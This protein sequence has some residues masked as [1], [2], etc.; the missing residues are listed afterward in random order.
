MNQRIKL[1]SKTKSGDLSF[2]E[3]YKQ[4]HL[5]FNNT[6]FCL[7]KR[8][9]ERLKRYI[10]QIEVMYW[11]HKYCSPKIRRK[12]PLPTKQHNLY[13]MFN[14]QEIEELRVLLDIKKDVSSTKLLRLDDIDYTLIIN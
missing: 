6:L 3:E 13:L 2:C 7:N 10:N 14:R 12:I 1:L 5:C 4:Y 9:L 8:E 11:E